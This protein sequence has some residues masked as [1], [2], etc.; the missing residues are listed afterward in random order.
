MR[1]EAYF[2]ILLGILLVLSL[3]ACGGSK[4]VGILETATLDNG[5]GTSGATIGGFE[6]IRC[7]EDGEFDPALNSTLK[8]RLQDYGDETALIVGVEDAELVNHVEL[9]VRY[10]GDITHATRSE[11]N[12]IYGDNEVVSLEVLDVYG[13]TALGQVCVG[14]APVRISGDFATVYFAEGPSK[15]VSAINGPHTNSAGVGYVVYPDD[16]NIP[17]VF[18]ESDVNAGTG[19]LVWHG[20]WHLAD[21]SQDSLVTVADITPIGVYFNQSVTTTWM[22]MKA[23]YNFDRLVTVNDITPVGVY[24]NMGTTG[25]RVE[26]SDNVDTPAALTLVKDVPWNGDELEPASNA[27][28]DA[29]PGELYP[30]FNRWSLAFD[31]NSDFTWNQLSALDANNDD[32]VRLHITPHDGT[33]DGNVTT[34][35]DIEVGGTVVVDPYRLVIQDYRIK[36]EGATGG[37]EDGT[38]FDKDTTLGSVVA[39]DSVTFSLESIS[40]SFDAIAFDGTDPGNWPAGMTQDFYDTAFNEAR[41]VLEWTVSHGGAAGFRRT[42]AWYDNG[43]TSPIVGDPGEGVLFPDDDPESD[44]SAPEGRIGTYLPSDTE[45]AYHKDDF[46][47]VFCYSPIS[48]N[49]EFDVTIDEDAAIITAYGDNP[50][51]PLTELILNEDNF[52]PIQFEFGNDF[53]AQMTLTGLELLQIDGNTGLVI[54]TA[55][56]FNLIDDTELLDP[57]DYQVREMGEDYVIYCLVPST[58]LDSESFY[59]F[60]FFSGNVWSSINK[61]SDMLETQPPPDP[62]DLMVLPEH[63]WPDIDELQVFY[64]DQKIRR[65]PN[66]YYSF[67]TSS[68]EKEDEFAY[69]DELRVDGDEFFI[70][71]NGGLWP[72]VAVVQTSNPS[73]ITQLSDGMADV[74]SFAPSPGRLLINISIITIEGNIG[75][76]TEYYSFKFFND[77]GGAVGQGTF[78]FEPI[79]DFKTKPVG[80]N[81]GVNVFDREELAMNARAYDDFTVDSTT[82]GFDAARPDVL[83]FEFGGG[84]MYQTDQD[85]KGVSSSLDVSVS[86]NVHVYVEQRDGGENFYME[87]SLRVIGLTAAGNT[88]A[89]HSLTP[90]AWRYPGVP[91]WPGK[92]TQG[93]LFDLFLDDPHY[94]GQEWQ[95]P[96]PLL[97]TGPDPNG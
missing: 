83:W 48:M 80:V 30:V 65:N 69:L 67:E 3:T 29:V 82:V 50:D 18:T 58:K 61:P 93:E 40:G 2:T 8:L 73:T 5:H 87:L 33:V 95:Y 49:F 34:F 68:L 51:T 27:K 89:I 78:D 17:N 42:A 22:A 72:K 7:N 4:N 86:P 84:W 57:G 12:G 39:N 10:D 23:D 25:Y 94:A 19:Q 70:R 76:E 37:A 63:T 60:R 97:V 92:F 91:G 9:E 46:L 28:G 56:V 74:Y 35:R 36:A 75:D 90:S 53:P 13:V 16:E 21:G 81:W 14:E 66:V 64:A 54:E 71:E 26:A 85:P 59:A 47:E 1:R 79:G 6:V 15:S 20:A 31:A 88:I 41:D 62:Q 38:I 11:M 45:H 52:V 43:D 77:E 32:Y 44:V 55:H 24:Y 96:Q